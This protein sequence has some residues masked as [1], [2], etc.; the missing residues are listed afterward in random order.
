MLS[1]LQPSTGT[2]NLKRQNMLLEEKSSSLSLV[3]SNVASGPV[4]ASICEA[5][6]DGGW[7]YIDLLLSRMKDN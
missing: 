6:L 2:S 3:V 7:E 1:N 4:A 5:P